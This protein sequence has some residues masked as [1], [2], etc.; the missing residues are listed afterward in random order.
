MTWPIDLPRGADRSVWGRLTIDQPVPA[1]HPAADARADAARVALDA[2]SAGVA[3]VV[4]PMFA[5][6]A[7]LGGVRSEILVDAAGQAVNHTREA[8]LV[9]AGTEVYHVRIALDEV[10]AAV[11]V[12]G[13]RLV[14][15]EG[16]VV[17]AT[18]EK[19]N[20]AERGGVEADYRGAVK[21]ADDHAKGVA[22]W[23]TI[24]CKASW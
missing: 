12:T 23:H 11:D 16:A 14:D 10:Q 18:A 3:L 21:A 24:T 19:E 22:R 13:A 17:A 9:D 5:T 7:D 2:G 20:I 6:Q 15:A 8:W 1:A 4:A